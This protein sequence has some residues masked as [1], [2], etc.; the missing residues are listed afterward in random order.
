MNEQ[1][2]HPARDRV[3]VREHVGEYL[4]TAFPRPEFA[5]PAEES[6]LTC[7]N[8]PDSPHTEGK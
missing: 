3:I 1:I 8:A 7:S 2:T 5:S 6:S 4:L